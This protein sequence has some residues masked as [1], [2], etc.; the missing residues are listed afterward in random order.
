MLTPHGNPLNRCRGWRIVLAAL[1]ASPVRTPFFVGR[2]RAAEGL[3]GTPINVR[4]PHLA[5]GPS[6]LAPPGEW[7]SAARRGGFP[8]TTTA[9]KISLSPSRD[10]PFNKLVLSQSNVRRVKARVSLEDL[11][12]DID[13]RT[14]CRA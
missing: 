11:A 5:S 12:E 13:R 3:A 4:A 2:C 9:K 14:L 10:I 8:V 6:W 7:L 1:P